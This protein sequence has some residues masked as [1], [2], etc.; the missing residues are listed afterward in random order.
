MRFAG[1]SSS[2][3]SRKK[4]HGDEAVTILRCVSAE[5]PE[6]SNVP[7][8]SSTTSTRRPAS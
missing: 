1:Y 7:D 8:V 4:L 3:L 2:T 5:T 6:Y